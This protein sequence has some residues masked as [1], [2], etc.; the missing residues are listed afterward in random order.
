MGELIGRFNCGI[1]RA[2]LQLTFT[3]TITS[4]FSLSFLRRRQYA[5]LQNGCLNSPIIQKRQIPLCPFDFA[6]GRQGNDKKTTAKR[7]SQN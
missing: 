5:D 6:Q 2:D 1:N 4:H 7:P 3:L